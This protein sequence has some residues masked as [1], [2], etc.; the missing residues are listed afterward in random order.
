MIVGVDL[1][2]VMV[3]FQYHWAELY[4]SYFDAG[5]LFEKFLDDDDPLNKYDALLELTHFEDAAEF[6]EWFYRAGGWRDQPYLRGSRGGIDRLRANGHEVKFI[7][8]RPPEAEQATYDWLDRSPWPWAK[9]HIR[10]DKHMVR[11]DVYVDDTP[12]M[13]ELL[14][15]N[16]KKVIVFDQP[17]NQEVEQ[18]G[19]VRRARGWGAVVQA[20]NELEKYGHFLQF[21]LVPEVSEPDAGEQQIEEQVS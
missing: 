18:G 10:A 2:G 13:V 19:P 7:T 5:D 15:E 6:F 21:G 1:D 17:W 14:V 4:M 9:L 12:A 8:N 16:G 20:V 11:A 3:D